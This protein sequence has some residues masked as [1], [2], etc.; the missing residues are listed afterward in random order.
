MNSVDLKKSLGVNFNESGFSWTSSLATPMT[1]VT[2]DGGA[3][4]GCRG[5]LG[6]N[7]GVGYH[8]PRPDPPLDPRTA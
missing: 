5:I 6:D 7:E 4:G 1:C 2:P 3:A 8:H